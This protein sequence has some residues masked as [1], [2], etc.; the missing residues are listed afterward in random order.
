MAGKVKE[1]LVISLTSRGLEH[2]HFGLFGLYKINQLEEFWWLLVEHPIGVA[3]NRKLEM[4]VNLPCT[5]GLA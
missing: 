4:I 2:D 5:H 3:I 1:P